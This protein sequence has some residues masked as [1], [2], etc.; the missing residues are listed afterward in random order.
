MRLNWPCYQLLSTKSIKSYQS[1]RKEMRAGDLVPNHRFNSPSGLRPQLCRILGWWC[2]NLASKIGPL[3]NVENRDSE[4]LRDLQRSFTPPCYICSSDDGLCNIGDSLCTKETLKTRKSRLN[5]SMSPYLLAIACL[6]I[7]FCS[8][9]SAFGVAHTL[10]G[11]Q[12]GTM[13]APEPG[14]EKTPK[15]HPCPV[16]PRHHPQQ[17]SLE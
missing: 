2:Q 11:S 7:A 3:V 6:P 17:S 13:N 5:Q 8:V 12:S 9:F 14:P 4:C 15:Q 1:L 16:N 10:L